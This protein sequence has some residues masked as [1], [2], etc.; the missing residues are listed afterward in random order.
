MKS[1]LTGPGLTVTAV[2]LEFSGQANAIYT[3]TDLGAL[4]GPV[5]IRVLI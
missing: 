4:G 1:K 2:L 5:R 3:F